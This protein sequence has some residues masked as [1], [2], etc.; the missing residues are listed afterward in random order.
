MRRSNSGSINDDKKSHESEQDREQRNS[1]QFRASS[2]GRI[3]AAGW[4]FQKGALSFDPNV[5]FE[6]WNTDLICSWFDNMGLYM[7]SNEVKRHVKTGEQLAT[8]TSSDLEVKLGVRHGLHRKKVM[9]ALL[10]K[11]QKSEDPSGNLDHQWVVRWLDDVGL[12]QYKDAFLEARID[13]RVLNFLTVDDLFQLKVTNLLHHLS[14]K[15]GI[16]VLRDNQFDPT[17][18]KR[19]GNPGERDSQIVH[20]DVALWTNH[21]VMEWLRHVDLSEYAPNLRGSGVHGSLMVHET[22]FT[23][24]LLASLLS[25]PSSKTLLRR[26]LSLHFKDL[27]GS[28]TIQEKRSA[29]TE[30][31]FQ[32]LTPTAKAKQQPKKGQFTLKRKKSKSEMDFEDMVCPLG[33]PA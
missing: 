8:F 32:P 25:I 14:L 16:Q 1:S 17:C 2:G 12:P 21:R 28:D 24:D 7:Y 19:R 29:E 3:A 26:H 5:P 22:K 31:N 20:S 27:V 13:G 4:D 11:M 18:L 10:A 23:A 33:A 30:P 15:R 9:L 6:A